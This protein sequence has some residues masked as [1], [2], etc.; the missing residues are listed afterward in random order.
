MKHVADDK[1]PGQVEER[2]PQG[3]SGLVEAEGGRSRSTLII[4]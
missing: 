1:H 3:V 2:D 4:P